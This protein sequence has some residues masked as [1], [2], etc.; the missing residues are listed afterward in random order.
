M[1][2]KK[3]GIAHTISA[4]LPNGGGAPHTVSIVLSVV[5]TI[6]LAD[7]APGEEKQISYRGMAYD[8]G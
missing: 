6:V 3:T 4:Y 8:Q 2:R 1:T 5:C 7:D